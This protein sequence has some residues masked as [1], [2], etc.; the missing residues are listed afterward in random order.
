MNAGCA[1]GGDISV[2]RNRFRSAKH[3]SH[4]TLSPSLALPLTLSR[5]STIVGAGLLSSVPVFCLAHLLIG[6]PAT[7]YITL[8]NL[9]NMARPKRIT[10]APGGVSRKDN[11]NEYEMQRK[12]NVNEYKRQRELNIQQNNRKLQELG[13]QRMI[14]A[15]R[16]ANGSIQLRGKQNCEEDD[17]YHPTD[18]ERV[19]AEC[20]DGPFE[21]QRTTMHTT[22]LER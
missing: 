16:R 13:I 3:L 5:S 7:M 8:E 1:K 6:A 10:S 22:S 9:R 18:D 12:D 20:D 19:Q 4:F 11:V 17:E 14:Q 21:T 2:S 15:L